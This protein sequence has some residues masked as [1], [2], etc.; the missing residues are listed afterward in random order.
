MLWQQTLVV[1]RKGGGGGWGAET[2]FGCISPGASAIKRDQHAHR[3]DD[4]AVPYRE[5]PTQPE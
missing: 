4:Y 5:A 3:A 1:G 2:Y